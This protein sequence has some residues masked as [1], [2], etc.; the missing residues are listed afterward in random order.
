MGAPDPAARHRY[1]V[2]FDF[3]AVG[4]EPTGLKPLCEDMER[5]IRWGLSAAVELGH[6][7]IEAVT[8]FT[9]DEPTQLIRLHDN[10]RPQP[11]NTRR[12]AHDSCGLGCADCVYPEPNRSLPYSRSDHDCT[13]EHFNDI[14]RHGYDPDHHAGVRDPLRGW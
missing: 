10:N 7:E 5:R 2:A 3:V 11:V 8:V 12:H 13:D 9:I 14:T 1:R 4:Y 6:A